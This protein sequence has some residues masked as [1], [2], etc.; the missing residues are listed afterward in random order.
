VKEAAEDYRNGDGSQSDFQA[1]AEGGGLA[2]AQCLIDGASR[3]TGAS[4]DV[5]KTRHRAGSCF[6]LLPQEQMTDNH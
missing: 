2:P 6:S 4:A 3:I 1:N 5:I